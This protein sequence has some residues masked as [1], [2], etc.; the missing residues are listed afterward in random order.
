MRS[1]EIVDT[2]TDAIAGRLRRL[3]NEG[4]VALVAGLGSRD[5]WLDALVAVQPAGGAD[6]ARAAGAD[7][8]RVR[9]WLAALVAGRIVEY[10][11]A[12]DTYALA[13][14][15]TAFLGRAEGRAYRRALDQLVR[16]A[17]GEPC[18]AAE[19]PSARELVALVPGMTERLA[20]G[21]DVLELRRAD[22]PS[23]CLDAVFAASRVATRERL[24]SGRSAAFA[25]VL[26]VDEHALAGTTAAA[27]LAA[28]LAPGG[29]AVVAVPAVSGSPGDDALHP[30]GAFLLGARALSVPAAPGADA[31]ALGARLCAAGLSVR[32]VARVASDPF[33]NYLIARKPDSTNE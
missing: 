25:L 33:R 6:V 5:G 8:G 10:D 23:V 17:A 27:R 19:G 24:P 20:L 14:D 13:P 9:A 15:L 32:A 29:A 31:D 21:A 28:A 11:G 7:E 22:V 16:L 12:R 30:V 4:M 3:L 2:R 1:A 26:S 18:E